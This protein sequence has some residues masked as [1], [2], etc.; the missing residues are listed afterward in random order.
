MGQWKGTVESRNLRMTA[1]I[2]FT[3]S[4]NVAERLYMREWH[5]QGYSDRPWRHVFF[6]D[7]DIETNVGEI[8][9]LKQTKMDN[10][11]FEIEFKGNGV[12]KGR[13]ADAIG[14]V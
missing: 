9:I 5:G 2:E 3:T 12:P 6:E 4:Y 1:T 11:L 7:M 10:G 13:L 14:N 8:R